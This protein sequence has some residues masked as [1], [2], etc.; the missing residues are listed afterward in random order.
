MA[1]MTRRMATLETGWPDAT[2]TQIY[3]VHEFA[4]LV[5]NTLV[6]GGAA[7]HGLT[8]HYARPPVVGLDYEMDVRGIAREIVLP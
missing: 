8:W 1:E 7:A 4:S 5:P 2:G 3:T 6:L